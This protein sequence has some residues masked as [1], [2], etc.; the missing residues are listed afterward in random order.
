M[1]DLRLKLQAVLNAKYRIVRELTGGGMSRVFLA[2]DEHLQREVVVKV[3]SPDLLDEARVERFRQEILQTA[4]LQ[5]PTVVPVIEVGAIEDVPSHHVPFYVMPYAKGESL[6]SRMHHEGQLSVSVVMRVLRSIFDALS[7]AHQHGVV[8]RDIK[9]ENIFLSGAN[10]LV[11]DFGIAKAIRGPGSQSGV[12]QPGMAV[13]TPTYMAPEQLVDADHVGPRADLFAAGVL[14]FEML[15]GKLPWASST[16]VEALASQ[17]RG[18]ITPL[19]SLR[20]DVPPALASVIESCLAWD[21]EKRPDSA[22]AALHALESV[23]VQPTPDSADA[24]A[25]SITAEQARRSKPRPRLALA[26]VAIVVIALALY[27]SRSFIAGVGRPAGI[28]KL[29]VLYPVMPAGSRQPAE[30]AERLYHSLTATLAPVSGVRLVGQVSVPRMT[31]QGLQMA[32][33]ADSLRSEGVEF[34]LAITATNSTSGGLLLA[35]ESQ[36]AAGKT[37]ETVAGPMAVGPLD[38]LSPDSMSAI[39][40]LLAAQSVA[41]LRLGSSNHDVSETAMIDAYMAW[42]SGR[43]AMAK[44]T[45]QGIREAAAFFERAIRLDTAYAQAHADLAQTFA[46]ALFYHYRMPDAPFELASR[47][48]QLADR[49]VALQPRFADG[50]LARGLVGT[51]VG[52]PVPYIA[53]NF[54]SV[55]KLLSANPYSQTWYLGLLAKQ[56]K[57][58]DAVQRA[59]EEVRLDPHSA[60]QRVASA[61]YAL[62]AGQ[63]LTAVRNASEA[64][65]VLAGVPI[66]SQLEL[67]GRLRLGGQA[68]ADCSTI[69]AGPYLGSRALC[70]E[71]TGREPAGRSASDSLFAMISGK[72][73]MDSTFDL[74]LPVGEMALYASQ[75]RDAERVKQFL[76]QAFAES[77]IGIDYRLMRSG[78]FE[79]SQIALADSLQGAAWARVTAGA[80]QVRGKGG[81]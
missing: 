47:A 23:A 40:R 30:V 10:A 78:M 51:L 15:T 77:P 21:P 67:W 59:E 44:R 13:G 2:I 36:G 37:N 4:R 26:A 28:R 69:P 17:A 56:G 52:A 12:T 34:L 14:A 46:L 61:I 22:A 38:G 6:R 74:A 7:Y 25:T 64:R 80:A 60:G 72:A 76:R 55:A 32:E 16:P 33:I 35:I 19:R 71:Q 75:H 81:R 8:H 24:I 45:P 18:R 27:A 39:V 50:Y 57:F 20:P 53:T 3:L 70:L 58:D 41:K 63:Y 62:P 68:L 11:A 66:V 5:H 49:A 29:A 42:L 43:D 48:L 54:E 79:A 9:P 1:P 73:R 65:S 31:E